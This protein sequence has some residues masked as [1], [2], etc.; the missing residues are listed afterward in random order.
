[1][2]YS[3]PDH[4]REVALSKL[5]ELESKYDIRVLMAVESGSRAWGFA[6]HDSDYDVRFLYMHR[7]EWYWSLT[8]EFIDIENKGAINVPITSELDIAGWDLRKTLGL[9]HKSNPPLFEW[10]RSPIVYSK[11]SAIADELLVLSE[12]YYS[13]KSSIYHYI[14]MAE[15]NFRQY[16]I[17]RDEVNRKKYLYV[18]RPILACMW[19]ANRGS[20]PPMQIDEVLPMIRGNPIHENIVKLLEEKRSGVEMGKGPVDKQLNLFLEE[21]IAHFKRTVQS[22]S[23]HGQNI[24]ALNRYF[25]D[26]MSCLYDNPNYNFFEVKE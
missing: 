26:A 25:R 10:L 11:N 20:F 16:L 7:P 21:K 18:I 14:N 22:Y 15:G 9:L 2:L 1:M 12:K 17:N 24:S 13:P 19:I 23:E 6:S 8:D 5:R 4:I 3:I